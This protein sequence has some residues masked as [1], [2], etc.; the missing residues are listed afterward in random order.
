MQLTHY[1]S[2]FRQKTFPV[3]LICDGLTSPYNIG[4]MFRIGDAFGIEQL[5]FINSTQNLGNKYKRTS[6]STEKNV[7]FKVVNNFESVYQ[8]LN[9][10]GYHFLI[11]EITEQSVPL[12][13]IQ[14]DHDQP[15]ALVVGSENSGV[16]DSILQMIP[17]HFHI[18]MYGVNSSMNVVQST[19]LALYELTNRFK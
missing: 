2:K 1:N 15:V 3:S 13:S 17:E 11:L 16:S 6:R 14:L 5:Y 4:G 10:K 18:E 19:G 12:Q 8:D 7:S 9:S